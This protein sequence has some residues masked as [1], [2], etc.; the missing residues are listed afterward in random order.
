MSGVSKLLTKYFEDFL[1]KCDK[2]NKEEILKHFKSKDVKKDLDDFVTKNNIRKRKSDSDRDSDLPKKPLSAYFIFSQEKRQQLKDSGVDSDIKSMT[3]ALSKMWKEVKEKGGDELKKY[4]EMSNKMKSEYL[5][6][7]IE[8]K[9]KHNIVE[10]EK[11]K[12]AFFYYKQA[13][14]DKI[15][16]EFP[17]ITNG[18]I[19]KKMQAKWKELQSEKCE[20]VK[21]FI[22]MSNK[23]KAVSTAPVSSIKQD[24]N[25]DVEVPS[26]PNESPIRTL[27]KK[28]KEKK[29]DASKKKKKKKEVEVEDDNQ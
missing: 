18:E 19:H 15:K 21:K 26:S 22:D 25:D 11:P 24:E 29:D 8:Y 16:S 13:N 5:E 27:Q 10:V 4:N 7:M 14:L 9:K 1:A 28:K 17:G 12:T 23:Q 6:K 3:E 20:T 2:E